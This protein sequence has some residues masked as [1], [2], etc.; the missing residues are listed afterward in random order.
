MNLNPKNVEE[1]R[2]ACAR[3][4]HMREFEIIM[5]YLGERLES[6]KQALVTLNTTD[7]PK[8]QGRAQEL[9]EVIE[10]INKTKDK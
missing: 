5:A 1:F 8:F 7:F 10:Q 2:T 9:T 6:T 3:L 4:K